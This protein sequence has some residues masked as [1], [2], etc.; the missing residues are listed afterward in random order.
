[1]LND[2]TQ[3]APSYLFQVGHGTGVAVRVVL[4]DLPMYTGAG[5]QNITVSGPANH[6]LLPG[7]N[8]VAVEI[9]PAPRP[10]DAPTIEGPVTFTIRLDEDAGTIVHR[11]TWPDDAWEALPDDKQVLPFASITRFVAD[12]RLV[13][14]AYW[15]VPPAE[16]PLE[17]TPD[18]HAAVVEIYLAFARRDV[19]AFMAANALKLSERQRANPDSSEFAGVTQRKALA[20]YFNREWVVRPTN[21]EDLS[22]ESRAGGR[23]AHVTRR[24]GGR[25]I[26]AVAADDP[27]ETFGVDLFLTRHQGRWRVFR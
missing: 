19:D 6:L 17:G 13:R 11:A 14:P 22:F 16:F 26:Q 8:V 5:Q 23:V 7:E 12:E 27:S 4:N 15:D 3:P 1:M 21:A 18:Q 20:G 2:S 9:F 25:V 24:D 10:A